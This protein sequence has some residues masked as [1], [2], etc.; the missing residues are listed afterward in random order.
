MCPRVS[1]CT[2]GSFC[3]LQL[4][5]AALGHKPPSSDLKAGYPLCLTCSGIFKV[6]TWK[7]FNLSEQ[8][9]YLLLIYSSHFSV[10][11]ILRSSL[12]VY[13]C[14]MEMK[15]GRLVTL[16]GFLQW[17][18]VPPLRYFGVSQLL[19]AVHSNDVNK[20]LRLGDDI[21]NSSVSAQQTASHALLFT[22][23]P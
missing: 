6:R 16:E 3:W 20:Q 15:R 5:Q 22:S 7:R 13:M 17:P 12:L 8:L 4:A 14:N 9:K 23:S 2:S 1:V 10:L 19:S 21:R 11:Q 18:K